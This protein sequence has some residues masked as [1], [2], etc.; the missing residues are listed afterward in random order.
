MLRTNVIVK[1]YR[2]TLRTP[3]GGLAVATAQGESREAA[4]LR[5][6]VP[7]GWEIVEVEEL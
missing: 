7:E 3:S 4:L 2:F 1:T 5:N 6:P